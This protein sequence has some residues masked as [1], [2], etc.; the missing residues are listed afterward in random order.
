LGWFNENHEQYSKVQGEEN[1]GEYW[2]MK[3]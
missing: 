2:Q 3:A 1:W